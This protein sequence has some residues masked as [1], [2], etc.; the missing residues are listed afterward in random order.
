MKKDEKLIKKIHEAILDMMKN[1]K[2]DGKHIYT[3]IETGEWYQ[4]V[5][6]VSNVIPKPW[7]AAWGA[8]EMAKAMGYSDYEKDTEL[9]EKIWQEI[10]ECETVKDYQS[11]LKAKKGASRKKSNKALV[12]GTAGHEWLEKYVKAKIRE[13][14]LPKI[15][16]GN[17]KR[18]IKQFLEWEEKDVDY[19]ILSEA[20]V[21]CPEHKF[22]GTLDGLAMM[23]TGRLALIDYKFASHISEDYYLQTAGYKKPFE[24]YGIDIQDRIIVRLPKTLTMDEWDETTRTYSKVE[25]NIEHPIVETDYEMDINV[26]IHSLPVKQWINLMLKNKKNK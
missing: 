13:I 22:A 2:M 14:E 9:A 19:W 10:K 7:L 16:T 21:S 5:S 1:V 26:F 8:K 20:I 25:N 3:N 18:P 15:P 12:D 4:G 6:T 17:L 24:K 23:K 11:I